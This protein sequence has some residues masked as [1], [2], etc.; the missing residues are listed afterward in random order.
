MATIELNASSRPTA[1]QAVIVRA[2]TIIMGT[3]VGLTFMFGFGNVPTLAL[4]RARGPSSGCWQAPGVPPAGLQEN[5]SVVR[6]TQRLTRAAAGR[7]PRRRRH[8]HPPWALRPA[9]RY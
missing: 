2:V 1:D 8:S 3:V 4:R 5:W 6:G 9:K 7:S